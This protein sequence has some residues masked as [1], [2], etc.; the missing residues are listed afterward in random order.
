MIIGLT[1]AA[2]AGK[3]TV[4]NALVARGWTKCA[5][6]DPI[7][8]AVQAMFGWS[9][10][11]IEANKESP[12]G[13]GGRSPRYIMQTLGTEWGR[14]LVC[15]DLWVQLMERRLL[16]ELPYGNVVIPGVRFVNEAKLIAKLGGYVIRVVRPGLPGVREHV[17]EEPLP[18]EYIT[19]T[20]HNDSSEA[21][22]RAR[23]LRGIDALLRPRV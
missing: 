17:S 14:T 13:P 7:Y 22:F 3:D 2:R 19:A 16:N 1:G 20:V 6:A 21:D 11:Y 18:S 23:F 8:A 9:R 5:F 10:E 4:A 12:I 15:D